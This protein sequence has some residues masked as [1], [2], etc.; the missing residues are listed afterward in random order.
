MPINTQQLRTALQTAATNL[1]TGWNDRTGEAKVENLNLKR[2]YL[3]SDEKLHVSN[4]GWSSG[5]ARWRGRATGEAALRAGLQ[6]AKIPAGVIDRALKGVTTFQQKHAAWE[7]TRHTEIKLATVGVEANVTAGPEPSRDLEGIIGD[8]RFQELQ[9]AK[10]KVELLSMLAPKEAGKQAGE[11]IV[12][13]CS[14]SDDPLGQ[15]GARLERLHDQL[16][17][18]A[19]AASNPDYTFKANPHQAEPMRKLHPRQEIERLQ[20]TIDVV[21][22]ELSRLSP[23]TAAPSAPRRAD[24]TK[25]AVDHMM[26]LIVATRFDDFTSAARI[27]EGKHT[28]STDRDQT[29]EKHPVMKHVAQRFGEHVN[30]LDQQARGKLLMNANAVVQMAIDFATEYHARNPVE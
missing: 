14:Q 28:F 2:V 21:K 18:A 20:A 13:S 29:I 25:G 6:Q 10:A 11:A 26:T 24:P 30:G 12:R 5:W 1:Q 27:N 17:I 3:G 8:A 4:H 9:N 23:A 16:K 19:G 15:L 7:A 22:R